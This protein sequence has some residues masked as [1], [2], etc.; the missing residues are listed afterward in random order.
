MSSYADIAH[1]WAHNLDKAHNGANMSHNDGCI[2]SYS[3][4]IGQ[5]IEIN[6]KVIFLLDTASYSNST[7]GHQGW[8]INA[9]P[10]DINR[11]IFYFKGV[12]RGTWN[13]IAT[14]CKQTKELFQKEL[15]HFGMKY[16][17][18]EYLNCQEVAGCKTLRHPFSRH[19]FEEMDRWFDV[20]GCMTAKKLL[21]MKFTDFEKWVPTMR[22]RDYRYRDIDNKKVRKF[23]QMMLNNEPLEAIVDMVNGEGTW[24][25]YQKRIES[26]KTAE[27]TRRL[28]SMIFV[29]SPGSDWSQPSMPTIY[30]KLKPV[31]S[32]NP[33]VKKE[34][35]KHK[36]A[37]DYIQ[38][39]YG[40]RKQN[41]EIAY[42]ADLKDIQNYSRE[43]AMKRLERHLG[44]TG[45]MPSDSYSPFRNG[46]PTSFNFNGTVLHFRSWHANKHLSLSEYEELISLPIEQRAQWIINKRQQVLEQFQEETRRHEEAEARWNREWKEREEE[47]RRYAELEASKH[48][49]IEEMK[50]TPEG[51]RQLYHEGFK[52]YS[53]SSS[54]IFVG[55][56]V[57][58]R[59]VKD[60]VE[61]S[62][63]IKISFDECKRLWELVKRWHEN[64]TS[65]TREVCH[66]IG[67][68]WQISSYKNDILTAGCHSI[69]YA[70]M[71]YI[72]N[73]L[74]LTA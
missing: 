48:E 62:K 15:I 6:D 23:I 47:I 49:Y 45:W 46:Q 30:G 3:T 71:E 38:W 22:S 65:F 4:C 39:L 8:A 27:K 34:I 26:L 73:Q 42:R 41:I 61:T 56:N 68:R 20:T 52:L 11:E 33:V 64:D 60:R 50:Q 13:I 57:L 44:M 66:A 9:I 14:Y 37:G 31:M 28:R 18:E 10:N 32:V 25:A 51:I 63:G 53:N 29:K 58:L 12:Q 35:A 59:I 1:A 21:R 24:E 16:L 70:E 69:A 55:G 54:A 2:Y 74:K 67:N 72:A 43:K 7:S 19:G 17:M 40:I 36:K 5:R